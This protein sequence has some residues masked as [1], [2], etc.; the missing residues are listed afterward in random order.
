MKMEAKQSVLDT[1][2]LNAGGG[3]VNKSLDHYM[4]Q[5]SKTAT[6][7]FQVYMMVISEYNS[8][9]FSIESHR[10]F[11]FVCKTLAIL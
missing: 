1:G 3:T 8:V 2:T 6:V 5:L 10:L 9:F 4:S 7:F 11:V